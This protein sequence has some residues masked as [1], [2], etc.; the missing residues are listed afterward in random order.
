[1]KITTAMNVHWR[2]INTAVL[3]LILLTTLAYTAIFLSV[4][5]Y[6]QEDAAMIMRYAEHLSMGEGIVWN[7][8]EKP[9]DGAT[10]FLYLLLVAGLRTLG[11]SIETAVRLMGVSAHLLL[12]ALVYIANRRLYGAGQYAAGLSAA[13]LAVGP[14]LS[15]VRMYFGTPVF[16]L[17][18]GLAWYSAIRLTQERPF[19]W[20]TV[21]AFALFALLAGLTRPEGVFMAGFMLLTTLLVSGRQGWKRLLGGFVIVFGLPG[22]VYFLWRWSYFGYPLPIRF[23]SRDMGRFTWTA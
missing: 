3:A 10:D 7:V 11:L 19:T 13:F 4:D 1:M 20:R 6:A 17:F 15:Y 18:V 9:V 2:P 16:A 8:G 23:M 21:C 12:V 22:L 14:G 5:G